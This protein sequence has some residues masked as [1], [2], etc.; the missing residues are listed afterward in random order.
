MDTPQITQYRVAFMT[1]TDLDSTIIEAVGTPDQ[2]KLL[3]LLTRLGH[4]PVSILS[5]T[6]LDTNTTR[7]F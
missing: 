3:E 2:P 1:S 6:D 4:A 5:A 7:T